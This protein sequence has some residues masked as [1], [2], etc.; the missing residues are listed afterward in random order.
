MK[1]EEEYQST[2]IWIPL[3][4]TFWYYLYAGGRI[5]GQLR[6]TQHILL[7][8]LQASLGLQTERL[9]TIWW[10][11]FKNDFRERGMF[12]ELPY[13]V[14]IPSWLG[15]LGRLSPQYGHVWHLLGTPYWL[16]DV[17]SWTP[18]WRCLPYCKHTHIIL[19]IYNTVSRHYQIIISAKAS[20]KNLYNLFFDTPL[21]C[22][23][24]ILNI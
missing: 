16:D 7:G 11:I 24:H 20:A 6:V 18:H 21:C 19:P 1:K 2:I 8:W 14:C 17:G 5:K 15:S 3:R 13:S 9:R 10:F 4:K 23:H 12:Y 22:E